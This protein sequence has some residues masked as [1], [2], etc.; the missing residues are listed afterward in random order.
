[1]D[2]AGSLGDAANMTDLPAHLE[3]KSDLVIIEDNSEIKSMNIR[4]ALTVDR[5]YKKK[6]KDGDLDAFTAEEIE[7]MKAICAKRDA[8]IHHLYGMA[9][10]VRR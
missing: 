9:K 3:G 7:E 6:L 1:M 10:A 5:M 4:F 8:Y 2:H